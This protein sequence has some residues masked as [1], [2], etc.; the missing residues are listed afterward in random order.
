MKNR[1]DCIVFD[2]LVN[3]CNS[4]KKMHLEGAKNAHAWERPEKLNRA[5]RGRLQGFLLCRR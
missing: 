2:T 1:T 3:R 4:A 5:S